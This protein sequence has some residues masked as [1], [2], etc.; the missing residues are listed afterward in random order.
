MRYVKG[1][2]TVKIENTKKLAICE[3]VISGECER[4][5]CGHCDIHVYSSSF[6]S[7]DEYCCLPS[8]CSSVKDADK[9]AV[10]CIINLTDTQLAY[11]RLIGKGKKDKKGEL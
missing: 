7:G 4:T 10:N 3:H 1:E 6:G 11:L 2:L 9:G 5:D 8:S